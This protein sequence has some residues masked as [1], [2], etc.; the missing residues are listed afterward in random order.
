MPQISG[1]IHENKQ[2]S[3]IFAE[4][5]L[6]RF[7]TEWVVKKAAIA[8]PTQVK[9]HFLARRKEGGAVVASFFQFCQQ[10]GHRFDVVWVGIALSELTWLG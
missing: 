2:Q 5:E 1:Q 7:P 3:S 9:A 6:V 10:A 8:G 4:M